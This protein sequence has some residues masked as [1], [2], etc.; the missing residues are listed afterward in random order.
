MPYIGIQPV[1]FSDDEQGV[2]FIT[3]TKRFLNLVFMKPFSVSVSQDPYRVWGNHLETNLIRDLPLPQAIGW[4]FPENPPGNQPLYPT[5]ALLSRWFSF[6][7]FGGICVFSF[8][9]GVI[10]P[11]KIKPNAL[12][13][14]LQKRQDVFSPWKNTGLVGGFNPPLKNMRV[15][16]DHFP[17]DRDENKKYPPKV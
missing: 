13:L 14:V 17:R 6:S 4:F 8:P 7:H 11:T 5:K 2:S 12:I 1:I 16:L 10:L 9:G 3:E 15:N